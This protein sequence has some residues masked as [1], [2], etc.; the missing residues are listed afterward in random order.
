[1]DNGGEASTNLKQQPR[2]NILTSLEKDNY[3]FGTNILMEHLS[4]L[5]KLERKRDGDQTCLI[6]V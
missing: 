6:P 4:L 1:M 5:V 3:N 2:A